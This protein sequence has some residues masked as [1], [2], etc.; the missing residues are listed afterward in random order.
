MCARRPR[1]DNALRAFDWMIHWYDQKIKQLDQGITWKN[2]ML[3]GCWISHKDDPYKTDEPRYLRK[4]FSLTSEQIAGIEKITIQLTPGMYAELEINGKQICSWPKTPESTQ[5]PLDLRNILMVLP[6]T[7][8]NQ[9]ENMILI[10]VQDWPPGWPVAHLLLHIKFKTDPSLLIV[11]DPTWKSSTSPNGPWQRAISRGNPPSYMGEIYMPH[12]E[13]G[14]ASLS[15][16][17]HYGRIVQVIKDPRMKAPISEFYPR[18]W[19]NG[20]PFY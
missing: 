8:L 7:T 4:T 14:W 18:M 12:F 17:D 19:Q 13:K 11:T 1:L 5:L 3:L 15:T 6:K 20:K 10:K 16:L 2:P 9:G